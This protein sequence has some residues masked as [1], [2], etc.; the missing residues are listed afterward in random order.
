MDRH[1]SERKHRH[2][3]SPLPSVN[4][5][6][7]DLLRRN[8]KH[9]TSPTPIPTLF[10]LQRCISVLLLLSSLTLFS[11]TT[12]LFP[13]LLLFTTSYYSFSTSLYLLFLP[14]LFS[15]F[16]ISPLS[17]PMD[18]GPLGCIYTQQA[19]YGKGL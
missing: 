13:L 3:P 17:S 18:R 12:C 10:Y 9:S 5:A 2:T 14:F 1:G 6:G 7:G 19:L 15:F 11:F 8:S 4:R 16:H